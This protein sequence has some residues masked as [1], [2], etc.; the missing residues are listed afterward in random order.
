MIKG[1]YIYAIIDQNINGVLQRGLWRRPLT[2]VIDQGINGFIFKD[3]N[4]NGIQEATES[5]LANVL[6][7]T[8]TAS[9]WGSTNESGKYFLYGKLTNDTIQALPPIQ[10]ATTN[11]PFAII[12]ESNTTYNF[13]IHF[14]PNQSDLQVDMAPLTPI[15]PGFDAQYKLTCKNA[16]STLLHGTISLKY[17]K[18]NLTYKFADPLPLSIADDSI[19]WKFDSLQVLQTHAISTVFTAAVTNRI[20]DSVVHLLRGTVSNELTPTDNLYRLSQ[21]I[22]GSFD[23]NDKQVFPNHSLHPDQIKAGEKLEY[24]IRFQNTGN[25]KAERV[26]IV[27]TLNIHLDIKTLQVVAASHPY[28]WKIK[29]KG[30]VEFIFDTIDLPDSSSNEA[31][32]HGFIKFSLQPKKVSA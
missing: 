10:Y 4:N 6:V 16:G 25:Y 19:T 12:D 5:N 9:E 15:R 11:P 1:E 17:D 30:I 23:P 3:D 32:S 29:E 18:N 28:T 20:G 14:L 8:H 21:E 24:T 2:D 7:S 31:A 27:D 26:R 13:G 22:V